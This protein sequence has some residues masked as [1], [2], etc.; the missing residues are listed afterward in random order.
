MNRKVALILLICSF[1][2]IAPW[3]FKILLVNCFGD[4]AFSSIEPGSE[5]SI[6]FFYWFGFFSDAN[7]Y[8]KFVT[9]FIGTALIGAVIGLRTGWE[10]VGTLAA[11]TL[12]LFAPRLLLMDPMLRPRFSMMFITILICLFVTVSIFGKGS[13]Q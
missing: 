13:K 12:G 11:S 10:V 4:L 1:S 3:G 6:S 7:E 2:P 9:Y 5:K 8:L